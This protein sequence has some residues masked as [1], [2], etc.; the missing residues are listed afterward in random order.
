MPLPE[1]KEETILS[2]FHEI[3]NLAPVALAR[4]L[5]DLLNDY[6]DL[7]SNLPTVFNISSYLLTLSSI[8]IVLLFMINANYQILH[9]FFYTCY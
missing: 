6:L 3:K 1:A 7:K 9:K 2:F 4:A 5:K 8:N